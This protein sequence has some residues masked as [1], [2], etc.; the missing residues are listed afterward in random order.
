MTDRCPAHQAWLNGYGPIKRRDDTVVRVETR[1]D[2]LVA[3]GRVPSAELAWRLLAAGD[4]VA[5]MA[6]SVVAHMT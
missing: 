6:M 5:C 3:S 1:I 2:R 4:R